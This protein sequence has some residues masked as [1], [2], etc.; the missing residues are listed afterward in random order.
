MMRPRPRTAAMIGLCLWSLALPAGAKPRKPSKPAP[1][2]VK[3]APTADDVRTRAREATAARQAT[4]A[5]KAWDELL[6]LRPDD[7]EALMESGTLRYRAGRFADAATRFQRLTT[8]APDL[9]AAFFNLSWAQRKQG[10]YGAAET[11]LR[12]CLALVPDDADA[13]HALAESLRAQGRHAEAAT[14]YD[15]FVAQATAASDQADVERAHG[16]ADQLRKGAGP[17]LVVRLKPSS[18]VAVAAS[19]DA[20]GKS[21]GS[22]SRDPTAAA[23]RVRDGD[24]LFQQKRFSEALEAYQDALKLDDQSVMARLKS[25]LARANAGDMAG[26]ESDWSRVLALDPGT[27]H[28]RGYLDKLAAK[29]AAASPAP[30][31]VA[32]PVGS[33]ASPSPVV[34]D[35]KELYRKAVGFMSE[36]RFDEAAKILTSVIA[37]S[38]SFTNAYVARGGALLGLR[39]FEEAASD[40]RRA[41]EL[42]PSLATPLFGLGRALDKLGDRTGSCEQYRRYLA[43]PGRDVQ[44][45]LLDQARQAFDKCGAAPAADAGAP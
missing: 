4:A 36:A 8:V 2:Q 27:V 43:S 26:A 38:A 44:A 5:A 39:R 22:V 15:A 31:P 1:A 34:G 21:S 29:K 24:A 37:Q 11:S 12:R 35:P 33:E 18:S 41:L 32:A 6:E 23:L 20:G 16:K 3:A 19:G 7:A 42:D 14:S 28:A 40:Y 10:E 17:A 9:P 30:A 45:K 25:G 13:L